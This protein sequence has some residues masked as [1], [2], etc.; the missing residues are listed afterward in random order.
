MPVAELTLDGLYNT[1]MLPGLLYTCRHGCLR[2][3]LLGYSTATWNLAGR[4][5]E[6]GARR[7]L[8]LPVVRYLFRSL[9]SSMNPCPDCCSDSFSLAQCICC[10]FSQLFSQLWLSFD[11]CTLHMVQESISDGFALPSKGSEA[12][13]GWVFGSSR[14][15]QRGCPLEPSHVCKTC[16]GRRVWAVGVPACAGT[17]GENPR[18]LLPLFASSVRGWHRPLACRL[19]TL[20]YICVLTVPPWMAFPFA[21]RCSQ[22]RGVCLGAEVCP[23]SF[24]HAGGGQLTLPFL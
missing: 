11:V 14:V 9:N 17:A 10:L 6:L 24:A 1:V 5:W 13:P 21:P 3:V 20:I 12:H 4:M 15:P 22:G 8:S 19:Q 18:V 16:C 23:W 7:A 2:I